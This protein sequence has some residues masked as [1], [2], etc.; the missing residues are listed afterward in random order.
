LTFTRQARTISGL[1]RGS[2]KEKT[3]PK[4][5]CV[6]VV[7]G[8][9][10][11]SMRQ[12]SVNRQISNRKDGVFRYPL[13]EDSD[14]KELAVFS[15]KAKQLIQRVVGIEG[16]EVVKILPYT[17]VVFFG[18][19]FPPDQIVRAV[20]EEIGNNLQCEVRIDDWVT[21]SSD[22]PDTY[23]TEWDGYPSCDIKMQ[24]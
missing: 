3:V 11:S 23:P 19:A 14:L 18:E 6:V 2:T 1:I 15:D 22:E 16:V 5:T 17:L 21:S 7:Q 20:V 4:N 24:A 12:F 8:E 13:N 10:R 9:E